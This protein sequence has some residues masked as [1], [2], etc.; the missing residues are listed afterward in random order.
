MSIEDDLKE[1]LIR[2][3][4]KL[5]MLGQ[6]IAAQPRGQPVEVGQVQAAD[7]TGLLG[8]FTIKQHVAIQMVLQG[9]KNKAIADRLGVTENTAKVH[10]RTIAKKL[11]VKTRGQ[12]VAKLMQAFNACSDDEYQALAHGLP[13]NWAENYKS[14]DKFK[15]LYRSKNG[16]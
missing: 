6:T 12:I 2:I 15:R 16:T 13:K 5:D 1:R 11:G 4:A 8:Q 9:E 14:P 10:I 3:E 7:T